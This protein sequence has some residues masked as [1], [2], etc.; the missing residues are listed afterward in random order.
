MKACNTCLVIK[1]LHFYGPHKL[2]K[3]RLR[4]ECKECH[5]KATKNYRKKNKEKV[6]LYN[7]MYAKLHPDRIKKYVKKHKETN[8]GVVA[9]T[10]RTHQAQRACRVPKW[11][12]KFQKQHIK[13]FYEAAALLSLELGI[14][15]QVDHI[16]P[17]KGKTMSGLHVPTNLQ[18]VT[19][20]YNLSKG[21]RV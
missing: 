2:T 7:K 15:L 6:N 20:A 14:E 12:T 19:K 10:S 5:K 1:P 21:N 4:G 16:I 18:V 11:L 3:D 8:P 9:L 13:M 17:L